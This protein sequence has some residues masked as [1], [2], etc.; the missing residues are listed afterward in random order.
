MYFSVMLLVTM[1]RGYGNDVD[2][3]KETFWLCCFCFFCS[4]L[5][6]PAKRELDDIG[7]Y[8]RVYDKLYN[9]ED[10]IQKHPGGKYLNLHINGI[11]KFG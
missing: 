8:W 6:F 1:R 2:W 7:D 10:F 11:S 9:L 4:A 5:L 3:M